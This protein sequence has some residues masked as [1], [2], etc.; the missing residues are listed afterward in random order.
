[1][2]DEGAPHGWYRGVLI[3]RISRGLQTGSAA[4]DGAAIGPGRQI[5]IPQG[6]LQFFIDGRSPRDFV[7]KLIA[8]AKNDPSWQRNLDVFEEAAASMRAEWPSELTRGGDSSV[9]G[10]A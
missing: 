1:M 10:A 3:Q 5:S 8:D 6:A 9:G 7:E 2:R 4:D